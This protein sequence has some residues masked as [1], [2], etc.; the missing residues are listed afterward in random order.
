[1]KH[2]KTCLSCNK[3]FEVYPYRIK[4]ARYCSQKCLAKGYKGKHVSPKTEF[5]KGNPSPRKGIKYPQYCGENSGVWKG[6]S[7]AGK[8][9]LIYQPHHPRAHRKYVPEHTLVVEK[10][11]GRF[12]KPEEEVH[13]IITNKK[14]D[15]RLKNLYLFETESAHCGYHNKVRF[16]KLSP[17]TKSNL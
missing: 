1:M 7:K 8:Y 15:N 6:G 11:L 4:I 13:H 10:H 5:K 3:T 9:I 12:L 2:T 16:N 14:H 17:I